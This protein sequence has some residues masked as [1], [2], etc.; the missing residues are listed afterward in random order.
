MEETMYVYHTSPIDN[1]LGWQEFATQK[2]DPA[3]LEAFF[4]TA[5]IA[6]RRIGWEGDISAGP[7]WMYFPSVD[8]ETFAVAWKQSNNGATFIASPY[9]L[10]WIE[11]DTLDRVEQ[12]PMPIP[13]K[14]PLGSGRDWRP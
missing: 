7:Y 10:P 12:I 8:H 2:R 3:R 11:S 5:Q 14:D 6:A 4:A 1:W 9:P 13:S